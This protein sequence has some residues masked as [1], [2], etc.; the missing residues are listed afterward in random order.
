MSGASLV[1]GGSERQ[2]RERDRFP[3]HWPNRADQLELGQGP[4]HLALA[5][6]GRT[7][8]RV[9]RRIEPHEHIGSIGLQAVGTPYP[10]TAFSKDITNVNASEYFTGGGWIEGAHSE[11]WHAETMHLIAGLVEQVRKD[12]HVLAG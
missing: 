12:Q 9:Q 7:G 11:F 5:Q 2:A 3:Y 8:N 1:K 10:D 4:L 6:R